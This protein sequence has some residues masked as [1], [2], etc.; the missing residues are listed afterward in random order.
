MFIMI[1]VNDNIF[2]VSQY[3]LSKSK[4]KNLRIK[5]KK[6]PNTLGSI[7]YIDRKVEYNNYRVILFLYVHNDKT[8]RINN[9][10]E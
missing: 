8:L 3:K 1:F 4:I 2:S 5:N 6:T 10:I 9:E 7:S